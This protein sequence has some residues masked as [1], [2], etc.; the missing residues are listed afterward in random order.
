ML[1]DI[2]CGVFAADLR[3]AGAPGVEP[4]QDVGNGSLRAP[5]RFRLVG[6]YLVGIYLVRTSANRVCL[7]RL[8]W[9]R[10]V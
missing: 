5:I 9:R 6:A 2:S 7:T 8:L 10:A 4:L 3:Q 1:F